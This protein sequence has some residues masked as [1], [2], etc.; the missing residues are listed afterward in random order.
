[1]AG[2]PWRAPTEALGLS[3]GATAV[4]PVP[5]ASPAEAWHNGD[6][7][8]SNRVMDG[9]LR[10][11]RARP[12]IQARLGSVPLPNFDAGDARVL[13]PRFWDLNAVFRKGDALMRYSP[14]SSP[15]Q[16]SSRV[17]LQSLVACRD[18]KF[19]C[20]FAYSCFKGNVSLS[21]EQVLM[22]ITLALHNG[23]PDIQSLHVDNIGDFEVCSLL[24]VPAVLKWLATKVIKRVI[25]ENN[26][27]IARL[28]SGEVKDVLQ[29]AISDQ[30]LTTVL[31]A[32]LPVATKTR[33]SGERLQSVV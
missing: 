7:N 18:V 12:L 27:V 2:G 22:A 31:R 24:G 10:E 33:I 8:V 1:M 16:I 13:S 26:Q 4:G 25:R 20:E 21:F 23:I 14:R 11:F 6:P 17:R 3:S 30:D 19:Q 28:A 5:A 32:E 29:A 9:V 15:S